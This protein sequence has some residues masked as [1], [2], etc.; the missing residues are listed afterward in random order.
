MVLFHLRH[1]GENG[2]AF[3]TELFDFSVVGVHIP[4]IWKNFVIIPIL[5]ARKPRD[6]GHSYQHRL[7]ALSGSE[8]TGAAPPPV[9]RGQEGPV[10]VD[11]AWH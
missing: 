3:L 7:S 6:Q 1:P 10:Q 8:D 11:P 5:K 2:L 9:H 4:A